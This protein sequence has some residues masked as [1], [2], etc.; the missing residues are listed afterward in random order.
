MAAISDARSGVRRTR[1]ARGVR[2]TVLPAAGV[3]LVLVAWVLVQPAT[4]Y[5]PAPGTV[6]GEIELLLGRRETYVNVVASLRR[7][8]L[9]LGLG[10]VA[11]VAVTVL[12]RLRPWWERFF[13]TYVFAALTIPSLA[14]ALFSLMIFGL[15]EI[16][17][18]VAVGGIVFP[19]VVVSLDEGFKSLD[20]RLADMARVYRFSRWQRLRHVSLPE[21][22]PHLFAAFR[23][24]HALAWKLV[25]VTEVFSQSDGIGYQYKKAFD[26]FQLEEVVAWVI[27]FLVVVFAV[28]YLVLRPIERHVFRWRAARGA[29]A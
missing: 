7:L 1:R 4:R 26:Y 29:M 24:A 22:S 9:G 23:N 20:S 12:M 18:Y 19:F 11:G 28:E 16:G 15:S 27:F 14:A 8:L 5:L 17:V 13:S 3:A 25:V 10:Y 21:M 2:K 6:V